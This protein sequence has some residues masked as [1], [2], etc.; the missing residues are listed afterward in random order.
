MAD[1]TLQVLFEAERAGYGGKP[2]TVVRLTLES[3]EGKR[4]AM[5]GVYPEGSDKPTKAVSIRDAELQPLIAALGTAIQ[6]WQ[7]TD[8]GFT[9]S[10]SHAE[11]AALLDWSLPK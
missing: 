8:D 11:Y 2:K 1:K 5:W 7:K 3:Y 10:L 6:L 4:Y 9:G